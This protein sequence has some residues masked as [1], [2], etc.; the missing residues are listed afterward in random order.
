MQRSTHSMLFSRHVQQVVEQSN[1]L[2]PG[3]LLVQP[4]CLLK[5]HNTVPCTM[6]SPINLGCPLFPIYCCAWR[7][8][9][10]LQNFA[11]EDVWGNV[12]G[13]TKDLLSTVVGVSYPLLAV[14][15]NIYF[16][17]LVLYD[18]KTGWVDLNHHP[19]SLWFISAVCNWKSSNNNLQ[20]CITHSFVL[21][22]TWFAQVLP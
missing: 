16:Q 14:T 9:L 1:L 15:W 7:Y 6:S 17:C 20:V 2:L 8:T 22:C 13:S 21:F 19:S 12:W 3:D 4:P 5:P 18:G 10:R 11:A